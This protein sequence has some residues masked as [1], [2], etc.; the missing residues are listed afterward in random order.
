[1]P[2]YLNSRA[3]NVSMGVGVIGFLMFL[4]SCLTIKKTRNQVFDGGVA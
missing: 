4:L 2:E 3:F 1:M